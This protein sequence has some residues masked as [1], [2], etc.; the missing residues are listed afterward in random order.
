MASTQLF[1]ANKSGQ[2]KLAQMITKIH[3]NNSIQKDFTNTC[4]HSMYLCLGWFW[5]HGLLIAVDASHRDADAETSITEKKI[6]YVCVF[7]GQSRNLTY[8]GARRDMEPVILKATN[9]RRKVI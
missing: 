7:L 4:I 8:I 1:L 6:C 5:S 2:T 9:C 3:I